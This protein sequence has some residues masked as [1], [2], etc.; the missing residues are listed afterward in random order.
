M[1]ALGALGALAAEFLPDVDWHIVLYTYMGV[2][3]ETRDGA[4]ALLRDSALLAVR[5]GAHRLI[6][7]TAAESVRIP[8]IEENVEAIEVAAAAAR[9][10]RDGWAPAPDTG[11]LAEAR[12][13][14]T[15]VLDLDSQ[16]DTALRRGV[17]EGLLDVPYCLHPDNRGRSR[18][19]LDAGGRLVWSRTG[20]LP[21]PARAADPASCEAT[22]SDLLRALKFVRDR[23]DRTAVAGSIEGGRP[24]HEKEP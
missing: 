14:I 12:M 4:L 11:V 23:Y 5:G 20:A 1:E 18:G 7:K 16:L 2:Y 8:T 9:R 24:P 10:A 15:A 6:V 17:E 21:V 22:S 3:P 13:I 19:S